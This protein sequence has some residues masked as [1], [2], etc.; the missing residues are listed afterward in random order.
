VDLPQELNEVV[1]RGEPLGA[2]HEVG[3]AI[4][5]ISSYAGVGDIICVTPYPVDGA[6]LVETAVRFPGNVIGW[7]DDVTEFKMFVLDESTGWLWSAT[8]TSMTGC[9]RKSRPAASIRFAVS[10]Q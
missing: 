1:G 7:V 5:V 3:P 6:M 4:D 8:A 10:G 9:C 2:N